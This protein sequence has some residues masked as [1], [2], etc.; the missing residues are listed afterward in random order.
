MDRGC[1]GVTVRF[2]GLCFGNAWDGGG[3]SCNVMFAAWTEVWDGMNHE[4]V[5]SRKP[6]S[7]Q[8]KR[9]SPNF[10]S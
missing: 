6:K 4:L 8:V 9:R 5:E 1:H 7:F 3:E 10:N 2:V